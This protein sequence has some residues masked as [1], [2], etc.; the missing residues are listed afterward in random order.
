MSDLLALDDFR[1]VTA[2]RELYRRLSR[3]SDSLVHTAERVWYAV[4]KHG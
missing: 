3:T 2:R 1:D 4:L